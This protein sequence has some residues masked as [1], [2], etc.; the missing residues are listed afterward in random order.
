MMDHKQN[1]RESCKRPLPDILLIGQMPFREISM[2]YSG[3]AADLLP[4]V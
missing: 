1:P 2:N 4:L 3:L